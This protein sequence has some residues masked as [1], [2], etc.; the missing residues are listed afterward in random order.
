[1]ATQSLLQHTPTSCECEQS[2]FPARFESGGLV[3]R[4][5]VS[6]RGL[7]SMSCECEQ[8][9]L[10]ARFE[11]R[12]ILY[13][14]IYMYIAEVVYTRGWESITLRIRMTGK[15]GTDPIH[16]LLRLY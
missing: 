4:V 3:S 13:I 10:P 15:G 2:C 12:G 1:M 9:C 16:A 7:V 5:V 11:S 6:P 8:S 14:S